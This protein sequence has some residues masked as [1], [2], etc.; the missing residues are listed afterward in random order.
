VLQ[1]KSQPSKLNTY[2][3]SPR[4]YSDVNLQVAG[5]AAGEVTALEG[6]SVWLLSR[7]C[8]DVSLQVARAAAGMI[9]ALKAAYEGLLFAAAAAIATAAATCTHLLAHDHLR[10]EKCDHW[11][12]KNKEEHHTGALVC[13]AH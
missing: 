13:K 6:A 7:M 4:V 5:T 11:F 2:G 12:P 1:A 8:S 10:R 9:A 3:F